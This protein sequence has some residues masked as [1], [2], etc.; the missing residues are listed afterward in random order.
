MST[1]VSARNQGRPRTF[2]R[3]AVLETLVQL[4]WEKGFEATSMADIVEASGLNKSSLY[5]TFGSKDLLFHEAL[6]R[7]VDNR[8]LALVSV[9][10]DGTEGLADIHRL[11]DIVWLEMVSSDDHRGCLAVNSSTELGRRDDGV[12]AVGQRF[13]SA[14]RA[15][16]ADAFAR[17]ALLGEIKPELVDSYANIM[18]SMMLGLA[19]LVRS[20]A[21][22]DEVRS[23]LDAARVMLD[24][25]RLAP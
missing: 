2:D 25:W 23:Q 18:V 12:V 19:V 21:D 15:A 9:L 16:L 11:F 1:D 17:A 4:F 20:G 3:D 22:H 24:G 8:T 10:S 14:M 13:R 6:N 5:N 7:Y